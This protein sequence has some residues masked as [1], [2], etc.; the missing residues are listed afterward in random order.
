[1]VNFESLTISL[2]TP[3][4]S[5]NLSSNPYDCGPETPQR[6]S[7]VGPELNKRVLDS[8]ETLE[9]PCLGA[10]PE[11]M[12]YNYKPSYNPR[13][14]LFNVALQRMRQGGA[15]QKLREQRD[16]DN[17]KKE[18]AMKRLRA[19]S[20]TDPAA[21]GPSSPRVNLGGRQAPLRRT[22]GLA[23]SA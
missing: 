18:E 1:M 22:S 4:P 13:T 15:L 3:S 11:V 10:G 17:A 12:K 21:K 16:A 6:C 5:W 23:R 7:R 19:L 20:G 14:P 8:L 2:E 9:A